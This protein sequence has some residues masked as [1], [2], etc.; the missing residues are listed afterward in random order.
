MDIEAEKKKI[1]GEIFANN[2]S[3]ESSSTNLQDVEFKIHT[4]R[5]LQIFDN[6]IKCMGLIFCLPEMIRNQ[7]LMTAYFDYIEKEEVSMFCH[8]LLDDYMGTNHEGMS[9]H[10]MQV[11]SIFEK[12]MK[13]DLKNEVPSYIDFIPLESKDL[14]ENMKTLRNLA[15][16]RMELTAAKEMAK[17]KVLHRIY[18]ANIKNQERIKVLQEKIDE[19]ESQ[20][21]EILSEKYLKIEQ[22]KRKIEKLK[23][24]S[25]DEIAKHIFESDKIML[26]QCKDSDSKQ[27]EM[28]ENV[29]ASREKYQKTLDANLRTE[30]QLR[31]RKVKITQ[32]LQQ[33]IAKYDIDVGVR[34]KEYEALTEKLN[35][36]EATFKKWMEEEF[37]PQEKNYNF[38][39]EEKEEEERRVHQEKLWMFMMNRAAKLIQRYW[40]AMI[41]RR[42]TKKG[43]KGRK[44]K[45]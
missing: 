19:H 6:L 10:S 35:E 3:E 25:K 33:W 2:E 43:R 22:Y 12:I 37:E 11:Q 24:E 16:N 20:F 4:H 7:D 32:Q 30:K 38:L 42:K 40:R 1:L 39:M 44:S 15:K 21:K 34:T 13:S 18:L 41:L 28:R 17:E 27:H 26:R 29:E 23:E 36:E 45:K 9:S 31:E 8:M 14:Y 5:V